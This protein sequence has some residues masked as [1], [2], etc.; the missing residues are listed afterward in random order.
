MFERPTRQGSSF[1]ECFP[2]FHDFVWLRVEFFLMHSERFSIDPRL[3]SHIGGI[4]VI[5]NRQNR[6]T[7]ILG[8]PKDTEKLLQAPCRRSVVLR[9]HYNKNSWMLNCFFHHRWWCC[10][11]FSSHKLLAKEGMESLFRQSFVEIS[12]ETEPGVFSSKAEENV[13][14]VVPNPTTTAFWTCHPTSFRGFSSNPTI[15]KP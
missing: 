10:D 14:F 12:N 1:T 15:P 2:P 5:E 4:N 9:E 7:V 8:E 13:E 3:K 11:F 6:S